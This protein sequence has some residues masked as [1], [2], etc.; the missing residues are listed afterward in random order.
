MTGTVAIIV[1]FGGLIFFHEL[2][3]F[4]AAKFFR[5]GVKTF[6]LGFGPSLASFSYGKTRYQLALLPLGGFV[7]LVGESSQNDLPDNFTKIESFSLRPAW[8][9]FVVI[10]SGPIFNLVLAWLLCWVL[11]GT[12][13]REE[14]LPV[15]QT[16][17]KQS[18]AQAV[19]M[20]SG[21]VITSINDSPVEKWADIS[22][23]VQLSQGNAL[24][25]VINRSGQKH[26]LTIT[27]TKQET[28]TIYGDTVDRW[29][30]GI[31]PSGATHVVHYSFLEAGKQG[32]VQ[33]RDMVVL[34][35]KMMAALFS[36][37]VAADNIGGPI[38]IGKIIYDQSASGMA[39]VLFIAALISVNLGILN[40]LPI[41]ILDGGQLLFLTIEMAFRRP[42]PEFIREKASLVGAVLLI[43]LMVFATFN[44]I[45]NFFVQK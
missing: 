45:M 3:H 13:G 26:T 10:A 28:P 23:L 34:T 16:V 11:I 36:G 21:D 39:N 8:Q 7:S 41:P 33:A 19:G 44:D 35:W 37:A 29:V 9:R 31:Q 2:G 30:L 22:P 5:M 15:I 1:V 32:L 17:Q 24:K 20:V 38:G 42:I 14:L 6:S 25:V 12:H 43:C 40:L 27:P 18:Q 4:L